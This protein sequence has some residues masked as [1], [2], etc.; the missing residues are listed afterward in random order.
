MVSC[1]VNAP[2]SSTISA[3]KS[4]LLLDSIMLSVLEMR[5]ILESNRALVNIL[6]GPETHQTFANCGTALHVLLEA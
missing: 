6:H 1:S 5:S 2:F 4:G 3:Q